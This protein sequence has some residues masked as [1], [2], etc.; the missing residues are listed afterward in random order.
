MTTSDLPTDARVLDTRIPEHYVEGLDYGRHVTTPGWTGY[1]VR[2]KGSALPF[3]VARMD[4]EADAPDLA[5]LEDEIAARPAE[6]ERVAAAY[7]CDGQ[8][9]YHP[10]S[11]QPLDEYCEAAG[12]YFEHTEGVYRY[13]F[14]D[15]S[16]IVVNDGSWDIE[17]HKPF[18]WRE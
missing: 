13:E 6:A 4:P 14:A 11:G 5:E 15:G 10:V 7:R 17:G 9:F 2:P 1:Y 16:A 18:T 12:G 8:R 3:M